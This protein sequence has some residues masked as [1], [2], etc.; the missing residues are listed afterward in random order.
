ML[1]PEENL[2]T[3]LHLQTQ[4]VKILSF[5]SD[6]K[7]VCGLALMTNLRPL[8]FVFWWKAESDSD[9]DVFSTDS[10]ELNK[11]NERLKEAD[12]AAT[13]QSAKMLF[14]LCQW[15]RLT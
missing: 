4:T 11:N 12:E 8:L 7:S 15:R 9:S 1:N 5:Q 14:F 13:A 2:E 3:R 6:L 10:N